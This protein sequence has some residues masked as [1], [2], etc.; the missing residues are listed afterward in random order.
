MNF[1]KNI[2]T[3]PCLMAI[4]FGALGQQKDDFFQ[5]SWK[6]WKNPAEKKNFDYIWLK[7]DGTGFCGPGVTVNG[8]DRLVNEL[9]TQLQDWKLNKDT[10]ILYSTPLPTNRQGDSGSLK[11]RYVIKE[12]GENYFVAF[13]SDP[14]MDEMMRQAGE[15]PTPIDIRFIRE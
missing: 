8:R 6:G 5:G 7:P 1:I 14:E 12:R 11:I 10:L 13:Y 3:I 9:L 2:L 15:K 4:C